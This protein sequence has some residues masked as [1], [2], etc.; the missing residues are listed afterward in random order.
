LILTPEGCI[1]FRAHC[2]KYSDILSRWYQNTHNDGGL[3][4]FMLSR[5]TAKSQAELASNVA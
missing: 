2:F 3:I 4:K 5:P 1:V